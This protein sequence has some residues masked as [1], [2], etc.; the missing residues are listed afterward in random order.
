MYSG[1]G[2]RFKNTEKKQE[3]GHKQPQILLDTSIYIYIYLTAQEVHYYR[4]G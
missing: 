3:G 4:L 1:W 2:G